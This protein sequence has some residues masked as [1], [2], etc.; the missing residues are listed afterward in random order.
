MKENVPRGIAE[1]VSGYECVRWRDFQGAAARE[2]SLAQPV[3]LPVV[4]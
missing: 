3:L 4:P 2:K 1:Q